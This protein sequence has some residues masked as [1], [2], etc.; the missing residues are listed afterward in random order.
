[1]REIKFKVWCKENEE[2]VQFNKMGFLEDG[3]LWYVQGIDE[4]EK[5]IDPPY[6]ENQN[7]WELMQY[8]GLKDKNGVEIYEGDI[9]LNLE[10]NQETKGVVV[11]VRG[12]FRVALNIKGFKFNLPFNSFEENEYSLQVLGNIYENPELLEREA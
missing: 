12:G 3:S 10:H 5:E 11:F 2:F 7:D 1:M 9:V 4:N 6:F 8:T